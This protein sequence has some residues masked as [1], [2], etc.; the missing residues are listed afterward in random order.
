MRW[1]TI[2]LRELLGLIA[3][4]RR[5]AAGIAAWLALASV[6]LP[7]LGMGAAWMGITLFAGLSVMLLESTTRKA[8][9]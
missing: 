9:R 3:D 5:L 1:I 8:K 4:D 7:R 2:S 6:G